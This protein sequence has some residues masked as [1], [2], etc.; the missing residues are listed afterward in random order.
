VQTVPVIRRAFSYIAGDLIYE[1][2]FA[3]NLATVPAGTTDGY[4][5]SLYSKVWES[6]QASIDGSRS[7]NFGNFTWATG[8]S[9]NSSSSTVD[10]GVYIRAYRLTGFTPSGDPIYAKDSDPLPQSINI[11]GSIAATSLPPSSNIRP[12]GI[13]GFPITDRTAPYQRVANFRFVSSRM[14]HSSDTVLDDIKS[15]V[16]N[17]VFNGRSITVENS[18]FRGT[19]VSQVVR[20]TYNNG[21]YFEA[22]LCKQIEYDAFGRPKPLAWKD[23]LT[24]NLQVSAVEPPVYT[25]GH[26]PSQ[27][28]T[29]VY[30]ADTD[31][32]VYDEDNNGIGANT[33]GIGLETLWG[34]I[35][36]DFEINLAG[37]QSLVKS[38]NEST[39]IDILGSLNKFRVWIVNGNDVS[40]LYTGPSS[41]ASSTDFVSFDLLTTQLESEL[42][43]S[44]N[45]SAL[46]GGYLA[47]D[48]SPLENPLQP[49][50]CNRYTL[51]YSDSWGNY[52]QKTLILTNINDKITDQEYS[53][54]ISTGTLHSSPQSLY[55]HEGSSKRVFRGDELAA[56]PFF[57][58][59]QSFNIIFHADTI[60]ANQPG[61]IITH[62]SVNSFDL[63]Q[64]ASVNS[65]AT[66]EFELESSNGFDSIT[67]KA[68]F[69]VVPSV[70]GWP[71][72]S[73]PALINS[74]IA[75]QDSY[76]LFQSGLLAGIQPFNFAFD[77]SDDGQTA[78]AL[79]ENGSVYKLDFSSFEL[80]DESTIAAIIAQKPID[81]YGLFSVPACIIE[82]YTDINPLTSHQHS[83]EAEQIVQTGY[84]M[85][86]LTA[87]IAPGEWSHSNFNLGSSQFADKKFKLTLKEYDLT[88]AV[89]RNTTKLESDADGFAWIPKQN[90]GYS[91]NHLKQRNIYGS[92]SD[93]DFFSYDQLARATMHAGGNSSAIPIIHAGRDT[94]DVI[95]F[96]GNRSDYRFDKSSRSS[97]LRVR[98]A[99]HYFS[100]GA[101]Y[102]D[103]WQEVALNGIESFVFSD[104]TLSYQQLL[105]SQNVI[106]TDL[107]PSW[108]TS[109]VITG[110]GMSDAIQSGVGASGTPK[111][112]N[113]G[114]GSDRLWLNSSHLAS[115][116]SFNVGQTYDIFSDFNLTHD[117]IVI[118]GLISGL[119]EADDVVGLD[120]ITGIE[121]KLVSAAEIKAKSIGASGEVRILKDTARNIRSLSLQTTDVFLAIETNTGR[122]LCSE[123]GNWGAS[124]QANGGRYSAIAQLS[125]ARSL[126]STHFE[127]L[128]SDCMILPME[129]IIA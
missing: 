42:V 106:I 21:D 67:G 50:Y 66:I 35:E 124:T 121:V 62:S 119:Y 64:E 4:T 58:L 15:K 68:I 65:F 54:Y 60:G 126:T 28:I 97:Q 41:Q 99:D 1:G 111:R 18:Q 80:L 76:A 113:S 78:R 94:K 85:N 63:V 117:R 69:A 93:G 122:I 52:T 55:Y 71:N 129:P 11:A 61:V 31:N 5:S 104:A 83:V 36:P 13:T 26:A 107:A 59:D 127:F 56:E 105:E 92:N 109:D 24:D 2:V 6:L 57:G 16:S 43:Q 114:H 53:N 30:D 46:Q 23:S 77:S 75:N 38:I 103:Y 116:N 7:E 14:V 34:E 108:M 10:P 29:K 51:N 17:L 128:N 89:T 123:E 79:L 82:G 48:N 9:S 84:Q 100:A 19:F 95:V 101:D 40:G 96:E 118:N 98:A 20:A 45:F 49:V 120:T 39:S 12:P 44:P 112:I 88:R 125:S 27:R 87:E 32:F 37:A 72:D 110:T 47:L 73:L 22:I 91:A 102:E 86:A 115:A 74:F 3:V 81:S 90:S 8:I 33:Q 70:H 25:V